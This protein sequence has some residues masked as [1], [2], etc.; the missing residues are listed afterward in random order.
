MEKAI[1]PSA[2]KS[3]DLLLQE[4]N[5]SEHSVTALPKKLLLKTVSELSF[6]LFSFHRKQELRYK[7]IIK[8]INF[9]SSQLQES[10]QEVKEVQVSEEIIQLIMGN[11]KRFEKEKGYLDKDLDLPGLAK[12]FGTNHSYL[13]RVVNGIKGKSF[14]SYLNDLRIEHAFVDLQTD[15]KK[16]RFT[17]EAIAQENGFKSAESFSKKFKVRYGM[18]PSVFLRKLEAA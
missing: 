5:R 15:P 1:L 17:I 4:N 12:S 3:I 7:K 11:L 2:E 14:K 16:R 10:A 8:K 6:W 13:S 18:Y 9:G